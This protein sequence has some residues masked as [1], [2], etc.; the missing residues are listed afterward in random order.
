MSAFNT[1]TKAYDDADDNDAPSSTGSEIVGCAGDFNESP[2]ASPVK[3][4]ALFP[5]PT[6][7]TAQPAP[8]AR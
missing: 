7:P 6:Q 4:Y 3:S 8:T 1:P 5:A 2:T